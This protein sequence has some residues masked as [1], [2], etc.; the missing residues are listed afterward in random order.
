MKRE[1]LTRMLLPFTWATSSST[2]AK[3]RA[4]APNACTA[5]R[6]GPPGGGRPGHALAPRE[7]AG[8]G[9]ERLH[10]VAAGLAEREQAGNA[11]GARVGAYLA[12]ELG[13]L[14]AD[15]SHVAEHQDA[16][17]GAGSEHVDRR[18]HGVRVRV[19]G[20]VDEG[21]ATAR[22]LDLQAPRVRPERG[23]AFCNALGIDSRG[24]RSED[25]TS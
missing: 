18:T 4:P 8:A 12:V 13:T 25:H 3:W 9:A 17:P 6:L 24:M 14:G 23:Q 11:L 5:A 20:I 2:L 7:G 1:P 15:F 19:V 10:R 22:L 21:G 16:R